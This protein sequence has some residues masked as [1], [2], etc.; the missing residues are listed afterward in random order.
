MF[1][2]SQGFSRSTS[3]TRLIYD[4]PPASPQAGSPASRPPTAAVKEAWLKAG[5]PASP[6][7][8]PNVSW[9]RPASHS[10]SNVKGGT[11]A[12]FL[13]SLAATS[14]EKRVATSP[15]KANVSSPRLGVGGVR[16]AVSPEKASQMRTATSVPQ[17]GLKVCSGRENDFFNHTQST[18]MMLLLA[19]D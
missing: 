14:P 4:Y 15:T 2:E 18:L 17:M 1:Q 11:S 7:T 19:W 5:S 3:N 13:P 12:S 8:K 9:L 16:V 6:A 10:T